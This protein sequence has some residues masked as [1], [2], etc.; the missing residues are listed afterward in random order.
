MYSIFLLRIGSQVLS[1]T[2]GGFSVFFLYYTG[3]VT[4]SD[5]AW[6]L[7]G[8]AVVLGGLATAIVY[9][10]NKWLNN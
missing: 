9:C 5:V 3:K 8:N 1:A 2:M 4:N 10:Q 6:Q 7:F